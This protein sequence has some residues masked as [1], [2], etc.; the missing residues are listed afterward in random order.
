[1][2]AGVRHQPGIKELLFKG[3]H[4]EM[5]MQAMAETRSAGETRNNTVGIVSDSQ[6]KG[7]GVIS[8]EILVV[9]MMAADGG[10]TGR[11]C[12]RQHLV[13]ADR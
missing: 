10:T 11:H 2:E 7:I 1:M 12:H 8:V 9:T 4:P 3:L 13:V 6:A 5:Q